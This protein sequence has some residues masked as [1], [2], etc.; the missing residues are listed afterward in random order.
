M[1]SSGLHQL[2]QI[3]GV[4]KTIATPYQK[5]LQRKNRKFCLAT[6]EELKGRDNIVHA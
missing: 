3:P 4:G 1:V 6:H 2:Q 5:N